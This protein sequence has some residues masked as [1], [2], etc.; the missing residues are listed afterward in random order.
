MAG[1]LAFEVPIGD[2]LS[3]VETG[4]QKV[5]FLGEKDALR[6]SVDLRK[7]VVR[8]SVHFAQFQI[9]VLGSEGYPAITAV[10]K[11]VTGSG[12]SSNSV[13]IPIGQFVQ[14]IKDGADKIRVEQLPS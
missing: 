5:P 4:E 3:A 14:A 9:D 12:G 11:K 6:V 2:I 7:A 8:I 1:G 10:T 13:D